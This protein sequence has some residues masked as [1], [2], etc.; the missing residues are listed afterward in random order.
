M[1]I[2]PTLELSPVVGP[3]PEDCLI[4]PDGSIVSGVDDGR[5]VKISADFQTVET[6]TDTGGRPLG[7]T[8]RGEDE[9]IYCDTRRGLWSYSM[10]SG[11]NVCLA[12]DFEGTPINFANNPDIGADGTIYFSASTT[13][14][15]LE[16]STKD[17]VDGNTSGRLFALSPEGDLRLLHSGLQFANGVAVLPDQSAVLVA[18]TGRTCIDRVDLA[19]GAVSSF[20]SDLPGMPDN[21]SVG[22]DGRIWVAFPVEWASP[23]KQVMALPKALRWII[24]RLPKALQPKEPKFF[25]VGVLS[26]A[27]EIEELYQRRESAFYFCTGVRVHDGT[28]YCGTIRGERIARFKL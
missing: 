19:T 10:S 15:P 12:S 3:D 28:A 7:L 14:N 24:A 8:L 5:L 6:L 16:E 25:M 9:I 13:E 11:E 27:G 26:A 21:L 23:I 17:I 18:Q 2:T 20:A 4:L 22:E 1:T